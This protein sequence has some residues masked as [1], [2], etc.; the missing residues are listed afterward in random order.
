MSKL[1]E[2]EIKPEDQKKL[3]GVGYDPKENQRSASYSVQNHRETRSRSHSRGIEILAVER[4]LNTY[5]ELGRSHFWKL[6]DP[7]K[8]DYTRSV[9]KAQPVGYF[10]RVKKGHQAILPLQ[11]CFFIKEE[12]FKQEVHNLI[13]MEPDSS[14]N[15]INGCASSDTVTAGTHIGVTEI[16]LKENARLS[17][18]MIHDW[19]D[20]IEVRPRT[21]I[22]VEKN[23]SFISN[24]ISIKK[25]KITQTF[26]TCY[27]K[28]K[29]SS[30]VFNSLIF[31]PENS[32][33][34]I[35]AKVILEGNGS[36]AEVISRTISD[37]GKVIAR[38]EL[39]GKK[40]NIRAHLEC[41]G[42]LLKKSGSIQAIP[43]LEACHPDVDMSHEASV[44]KIAEEEIYYLMSR[45][46]SEEK[47]ISLIVRGFLDTKI[48]GLP[49]HLENEVEKTIDLLDNAF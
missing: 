1:S 32:V 18:T 36:R 25:S 30:G 38:G 31:A 24:Y 49:A 23:G 44:G 27:L 45:G 28:G 41:S 3:L 39:V 21:A 29:N 10:I 34:D 5:P 8:D 7:D 37:G 15:I 48:L 46:I 42:M 6:I 2:A 22:S 40:Q 20:E 43:V 17:Y 47:A 4:A 11:A 19:S 12:R 26:P 14:L 13:V 9:A 16:Y 33:Y 35:G